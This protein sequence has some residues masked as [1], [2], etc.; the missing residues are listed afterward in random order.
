M[1]PCWTDFNKKLKK[2]QESTI[3]Y[4][5][6]RKIEE[7]EALFI[8]PDLPNLNNFDGEQMPEN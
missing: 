3:K 5:G 1:K 2:T 7:H 6:E 8:S 4:I